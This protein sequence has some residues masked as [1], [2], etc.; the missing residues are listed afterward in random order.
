MNK[1]KLYIINFYHLLSYS[2][3]K[4]L[5]HHLL[6]SIFQWISF[7]LLTATIVLHSYSSGIFLSL[8]MLLNFS[9]CN[10]AF[11]SHNTVTLLHK[12]VNQFPPIS[13]ALNISLII[14]AWNIILSL[15]IFLYLFSSYNIS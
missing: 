11:F 3:F 6:K 9:Y 4:H 5:F 10:I 15:L 7:A 2:I 1:P 13:D 14:L 12:S 8:A